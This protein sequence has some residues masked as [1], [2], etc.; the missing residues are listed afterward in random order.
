MSTALTTIQGSSTALATDDSFYDSLADEVGNMPGGGNGKA[1]L[2]F[3]GN[4]GDYSYGSK[5]EELELG[6]KVVF[7]VDSYARGYVCWVDGKVKDEKMRE[8]A[9]GLPRLTERELPDHGPY[10]DDDDGWSEQHTIDLVMMDDPYT[11]MIFQANNRSKM[12]ALG[13]FFKDWKN[14]YKKHPGCLPV[15]EMDETEFEAKT[16]KG[17]RTVTKHAPVFTIVDWV[18]KEDLIKMLEGAAEDYDEEDEKPRR[19]KKAKADEDDDRPARRSRKAE[20]EEEEDEKPRR[21]SR[22]DEEDEEEERP[23]RSSK[24]SRDPEPEELEEE[25]E[26]EDEEEDKTSRRRPTRRGRF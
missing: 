20:A 26:A 9:S 16:G 23:R 5:N 18:S 8:A 21:R 7:V 22:R 15:V 17:N 11:T 25:E 4:S 1:F 6:S 14:N 12:N 13:S 3:D 10:E 2:K 24:R 19:S